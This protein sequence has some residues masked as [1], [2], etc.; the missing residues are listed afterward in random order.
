MFESNH[1]KMKIKFALKKAEKKKAFRC[2]MG[3]QVEAKAFWVICAALV[4]RGNRL[5]A[6]HL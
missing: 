1:L 2:F 4:A 6:F 3:T 5:A